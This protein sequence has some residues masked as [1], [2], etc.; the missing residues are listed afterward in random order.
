MVSNSWDTF[1][2]VFVFVV[3]VVFDVVDFVVLVLVVIVVVDPTNLPWLKSVQKQLRYW[4]YWVCVVGGDGSGG[5]SKPI[6]MSNPTF[7]FC[8]G[9][10]G[11]V[12]LLISIFLDSAQENYT[13]PHLKVP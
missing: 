11:M 8:W 9:W 1:V 13:K 7:E 2:A 5:C 3:V 4:W 6:F 10:V 12:T